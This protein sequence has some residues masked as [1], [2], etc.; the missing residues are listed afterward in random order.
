MMRTGTGLTTRMKRARVGTGSPRCSC[1][2]AVGVDRDLAKYEL[3]CLGYPYYSYLSPTEVEPG[4]GGE[5]A[6]PLALP[7][8]AERQV[9]T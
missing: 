2:S 5:T 1:T 9:S 3:R 6:L 8:D 7:I 4:S